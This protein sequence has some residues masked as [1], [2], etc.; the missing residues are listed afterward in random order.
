MSVSQATVNL[1]FAAKN[2]ADAAIG[3]LTG[4]LA[5]VGE[6]GEKAASR[7]AGAFRGLGGAM[8]N[9]IGNA[10][11]T[12]AS[13]G[14]FTEALSQTGIY[15][16]G[17]LAEQF[18]GNLI[19]RLGSSSLVAMIAAPL[20]AIGSAIGGLIAA[21]IPIG[22][23]ALPF[24]LIGALI[25][26][27]TVLIVNPEV[28]QKVFNFVGDLIGKIG[29]F[30]SK[31]LEILADIIPKAFQAAWNF[32]V[33]NVPKIIQT[34]VDFWQQLPFKL[35]GLGGDIL[36]TIIDGLAGLG[37]AVFNIISDAFTNLRI[38]IGPFHIRSTGVTIDLPNIQLPSF[39]VGSP[40][41]PRDMVA[42]VHEGEMIIPRRQ[43]DAMRSGSGGGQG[44]RLVGVTE[45]DI[46]DM[47]DR[48]LYFRLRA[49]G[50]A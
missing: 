34:L 16:A 28:R 32:V 22:M 25:A 47:I 35:I 41:V 23:A 15:M 20:G 6:A 42:K 38:D 12:L 5:K 46:A 19:E 8:A 40:Y 17:Q 3:D 43:A 26:A 27:I 2:M 1:V 50:V 24:I 29:D 18:G 48:G 30:L 39:D 9:A 21:A 37:R 10:T 31:G 33:E 45:S 44:V 49:A 7:F 14:S 36:R 4:S 13:G 11:E